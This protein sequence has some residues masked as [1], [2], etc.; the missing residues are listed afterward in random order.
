MLGF[1]ALLRIH[2]CQL[3]DGLACNRR[4]SIP[5]VSQRH[6]ATLSVQVVS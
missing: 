1:A 3:A 2:T 4:Q 5:T 6:S